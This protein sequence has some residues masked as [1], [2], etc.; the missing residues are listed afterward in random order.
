MYQPVLKNTCCKDSIIAKQGE[1]DSSTRFS[2]QNSYC[3]NNRMDNSQYM[4][5]GQEKKLRKKSLFITK[6]V[7]FKNGL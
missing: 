4:N 2:L 1:T 3:K 5:H 6:H 7:H